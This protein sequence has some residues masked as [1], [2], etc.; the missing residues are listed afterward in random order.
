[1]MN[2]YLQL[3]TKCAMNV[4]KLNSWRLLKSMR[5]K[6]IKYKF[7]YPTVEIAVEDPNRYQQVCAPHF[8]QSIEI[9]K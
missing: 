2:F 8:L 7:Q 6:K 5:K 3:N 1:M 4:E 9:L